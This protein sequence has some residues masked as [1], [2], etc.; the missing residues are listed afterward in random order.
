MA[1]TRC[2]LGGP[3]VC[4]SVCQFDTLVSG[5]SDVFGNER[6]A[7]W[8]GVNGTSQQE[9]WQGAATGYWEAAWHGWEP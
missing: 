4:L 5:K 3:C 8:A 6:V 9:R 7:D 2:P 1:R